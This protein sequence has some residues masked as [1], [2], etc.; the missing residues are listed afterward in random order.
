MRHVTL[1]R[2]GRTPRFFRAARCP[3]NLVLKSLLPI[4]EGA[5]YY[6]VNS[7]GTILSREI[8]PEATAGVLGAILSAPVVAL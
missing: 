3:G 4:E 5:S 2:E 7:H 6:T 8:V 1:P